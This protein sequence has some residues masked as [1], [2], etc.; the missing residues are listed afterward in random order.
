MPRAVA[1]A[2]AENIY[3]LC[4]CKRRTVVGDDKA[5]QG[6]VRSQIRKIRHDRRVALEIA[7][8]AQLCRTFSL[9]RSKHLRAK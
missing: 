4:A 6:D 1:G 3:F 2:G 7:E 8:G 9:S 5:G